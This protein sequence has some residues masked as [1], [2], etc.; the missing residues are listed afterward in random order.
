MVPSVLSLSLV[1]AGSGGGREG[2]QHRRRH[3]RRGRRQ[4]GEPAEDLCK[5]INVRVR[6]R[7]REGGRE[8][9]GG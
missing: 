3:G 2:S 5:W 8:M 9:S 6:E 4:G 1:L 7:E